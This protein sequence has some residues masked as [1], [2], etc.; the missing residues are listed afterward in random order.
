MAGQVLGRRLYD[1]MGKFTFVFLFWLCLLTGEFF[2]TFYDKK[3]FSALKRDKINSNVFFLICLPL[4][5]LVLFGCYTLCSIG[6]HL[7]VLEDCTEAHKE[8]VGQ[9][10][11]A[12]ADL[13]KKGFKG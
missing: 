6:W 4:H 7:M 12:K 5:A 1:V 13:K 3:A 11:Q 10:E 2:R 8:L 9:I